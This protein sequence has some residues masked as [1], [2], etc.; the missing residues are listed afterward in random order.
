MDNVIVGERIKG[1]R[2]ERKMTREELAEAAEL[3]VSFLYEIETG[4]KEFLCLYAWKL[5]KSIKGGSGLHTAGENG[6]KSEQ[7]S[8]EGKPV[9]YPTDFVGGL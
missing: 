4:K 3:S 6:R 8:V 7:R 5:V 2:L 9:L 1:L